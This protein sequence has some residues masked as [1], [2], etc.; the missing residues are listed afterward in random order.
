MQLI[1][2]VN[3][4]A[5]GS[6]SF[7]SLFDISP[8]S[9]QGLYQIVREMQEMSLNSADEFEESKEEKTKPKGTVHPKFAIEITKKHIR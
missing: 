5:V 3:Q 1:T 9:E 6:K 4:P 7:K 8:R 2:P